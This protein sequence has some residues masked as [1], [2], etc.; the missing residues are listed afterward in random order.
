LGAAVLSLP[1]R[2]MKNALLGTAFALATSL[3]ASVASAQSSTT[4]ADSLFERG[5]TAM[6]SGDYA[7]ACANFTESHR[8][9]PAAGTQLNLAL[10]QERL[11]KLLSARKNLTEVLAKLPRGDVRVPIAEKELEKVAGR[12]PHVTLTLDNADAATRVSCD[13]VEIAAVERPIPLDP[14]AH[15][16]VVTSDGATSTREVVLKEGEQLAL[17]LGAVAPAKVAASTHV[18]RIGTSSDG[19]HALG[20]SALAVGGLGIVTGIVTG[21]MT[22]DAA[23]TYEQHCHT[24]CD[25]AGT[26]AKLRGRT[27][28]VVSPLAFAI[29]ALGG[30]VGAYLLLTARDEPTRAAWSVGP[31]VSTTEAGLALARSF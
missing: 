10:C 8:L 15:H 29:G 21:I 14:G 26:D 1:D 27:L 25:E 22:A 2:P 17:R 24:S 31:H 13:G 23:G 12:L 11:G 7:V 20:Y 19:R 4:S 16:F 28:G 6:T 9:E 30:G 3:F 18:S 5:R